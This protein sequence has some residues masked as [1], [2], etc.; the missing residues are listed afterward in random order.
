[1]EVI[2]MNSAFKMTRIMDA[3]TSLIWNDYYIGFGDFEVRLPMTDLALIG[4]REGYYASIKESDRYMIVESIN[5]TTDV[6]DGNYVVISGRSLESILD[7]RIIRNHTILTGSFQDGIMRIINANLS[8][9]EDSKRQIARVIFEK[10]DDPL[11]LKETIDLEIDPGEILYNAIYDMCNERH[12]GFKMLPQE[13][14][15]MKFSLYYGVDRSYS[16]EKNPW[17]VFS[18][19]FENIKE[20]SMMMDTTNLRTTIIAETTYTWKITHSDGESQDVE[21][22][23]TVSVGDDEEGMDRREIYLKGS[24][25]PESVD[26]ESFGLAT[27]RV[28]YY[29]YCEWI[30]VYFN[31][32][33]Y[34]EDM[35]AY[36][37]KYR[38]NK[39]ERATK[40]PDIEWVWYKP[41]D[42][43]YKE[44]YDWNHLINVPGLNGYW[45][46]T[47][48]Y[49][50]PLDNYVARLNSYDAMMEGEKPDIE[51]YYTYGWDL[52]DYNGY[53]NAIKEAQA[54]IDKEYKDALNNS[55]EVVRKSLLE[56]ANE[57]LAPYQRISEFDGEV[58]S[59]VQFIFGRDYYLGDLVQVVNEY[60]FQAKT[61]VVG[62]MF[63]EE[64]G[65]GTLMVPYFESDDKAVFEL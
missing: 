62:V 39:P 61:R 16:Q 26:K 8:N 64:D 48:G 45:E 15:T 12:I 53:Q 51:D 5:I 18:P 36:W 37:E 50:E 32:T 46:K 56:K 38:A 59:N 27:D 1:M 19:N 4:V 52:T 6:E 65:V 21:E 11:I 31:S 49:E 41:G 25:R 30:P 14:G 24:V 10:S 42:E 58:D 7:R 54:E 44:E 34:N 43:N 60:G 55:R 17:V 57:E 40:D 2:F 35:D 63:S 33:K 20:T 22:T 9:P 23:I 13:D 28:N 3:F 29:D 47:E